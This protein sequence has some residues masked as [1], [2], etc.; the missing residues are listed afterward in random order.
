MALE[1]V[2]R[3]DGGTAGVHVSGDDD[4]DLNPRRD[5][6]RV[7]EIES[8]GQ[9]VNVIGRVIGRVAERGHHPTVR[10]E[11]NEPLQYGPDDRTRRSAIDSHRTADERPLCPRVP[12]RRAVQQTH[13]VWQ[14]GVQQPDQHRR[15]CGQTQMEFR[16]IRLAMRIY[17]LE[18]H[19]CVR[20]IFGRLQTQTQ[21]RTAH[22]HRGRR[23][24]ERWTA[25]ARNERAEEEQRKRERARKSVK[26]RERHE[27]LRWGRA[28]QSRAHNS[29]SCAG[30]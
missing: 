19:Q 18:Q 8:K 16:R 6:L 14:Y 2:D 26:G 24:S 12:S 5:V 11:V 21:T 25:T 4:S 7:I 9:F 23:Q 13:G 20:R 10:I 29:I 1:I 22:A 15:V 17:R 28:P 3:L 30:V 27:H